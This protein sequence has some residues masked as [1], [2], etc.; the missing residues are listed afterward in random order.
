MQGLLKGQRVLVAASGS[1]AAVKTPLLVS[2]LVQAGAQVRC[3]ITASAARLVSPVA[4]ATLSRHPCFQ[5]KDQ[6]DPGR[7]R[8]LH[9]ELAEWADLLVVAPLSATSLSR[10]VQ[11]DG[12]GLLASLLLACECP[13]V[14]APAMNTAMWRHSAVQRNWRRLLDDPRVLPLAP[15]GGLLACDRLGTGR[16]ADPVRIE[17]AAASALLQADAEGLLKSDWRGR[18]VLVSAGPTLESLDSVRV[19]SN[20]SSGRMGVLLAQ[21]AHLRGATV[22]LVHGPLQVSPSWLEGLDCH[23]VVGS[24]AMDDLL[25]QLQPKADA[26]LMCAAVADLRRTSAVDVEKL[27]KDKLVESIEG[28][29]ELVPDLLQG[30]VRRRPAGQTVLGF[31]AL[32]GTDEQLLEHGRRKLQSKGCDLLMVNPV[33]RPGQGLDSDQNSGWL[34]GPGHRHQICPLESKLVLSHRLLDR[35]LELQQS[36]EHSSGQKDA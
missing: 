23:A 19:F 31:A 7:P 27:P 11:G 9:I 26:V 22:D 13:V 12:D 1:I 4:L 34:L 32:T 30:L 2:A 8:P 10:W 17:L 20:R 24:A 5:D 28:G 15:E 18:H 16:M 3:V 6:W 14:A 25:R 29:W 36:S 21:A 35:L 33:D